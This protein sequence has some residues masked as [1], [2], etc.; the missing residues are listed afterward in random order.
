MSGPAPY[1]GGVLEYITAKTEV[2]I[3]L[4]KKRPACQY[5]LSWCRY[6]RDFDRYTCRLTGEPLFEISKSIGLLCPARKEIEGER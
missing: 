2:L 1:P 3:F 5:C 4:P 6:E